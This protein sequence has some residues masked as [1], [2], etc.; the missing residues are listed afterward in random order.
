VR[1]NNGLQGAF[2]QLHIMPVRPVQYNT[3]G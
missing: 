2:Q 3:D 1:G